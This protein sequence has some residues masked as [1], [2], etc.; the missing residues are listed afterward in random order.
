V[1]VGS[2]ERHLTLGIP[3]IGAMCVSFDELPDGEPVRGF[4]WRDAY[5]FAH[6]SISIVY[7]SE[8]LAA[9]A[10]ISMSNT[11]LLT[12]WPQTEARLS[13]GLITFSTVA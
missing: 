6:S 10:S 12:S 11:A 1:G 8:R 7:S 5:V 13:A 4:G 9:S 3:T 2:K